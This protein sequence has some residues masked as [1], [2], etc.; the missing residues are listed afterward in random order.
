MEARKFSWGRPPGYYRNETTRKK[1]FV[2]GS[3]QFIRSDREAELN[4]A[5]Q[6]RALGY[7][8]ATATRGGPDGGI[9][10]WSSRALA[11]VKCRAEKAGQ[12]DLQRLYG[13]RG[14]DHEKELWFFISSGYTNSTF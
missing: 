11:Q 6:L 12:P 8:D 2:S 5:A 14:N 10:V 1:I 4:A 13:A 9:D 7:R 3:A